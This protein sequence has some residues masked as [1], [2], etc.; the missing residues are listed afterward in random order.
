MIMFVK[1]KYY[2]QFAYYE[3]LQ[4]F[5]LFACLSL[6]KLT[7]K[8]CAAEIMFCLVE[9]NYRYLI[10][11]LGWLKVPQKFA[12]VGGGENLVINFGYSLALTKPNN[13]QK[14]FNIS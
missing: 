9:F 10:R 2:S 14:D 3:D 1:F 12:L 5:C 7:G 6:T 13:N 8:F 11:F 4:C